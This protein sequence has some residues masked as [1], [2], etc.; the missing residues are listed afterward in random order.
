[1]TNNNINEIAELLNLIHTT[2]NEAHPD[3]DD[4]VGSIIHNACLRIAEVL[5]VDLP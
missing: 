4:D 3:P 1:M 5:G 2:A